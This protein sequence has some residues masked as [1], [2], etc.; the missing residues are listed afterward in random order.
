MS[1][2]QI[3]NQVVWIDIPCRDLDRAIGFY[4]TVLGCAV[5]K[6][7]GKKP[8]GT[9]FELGVLAHSGSEV[10]GCLIVN[11]KS[12]P[13]AHG[14]LVY[15]NCQGRLKEAVAA[16]EPHGGKILEPIHGIGPYGSRA[17]ILDSEGNR[18]ALHST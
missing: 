10:G 4:S 15:L 5:E 8:D 18:V 3:H 12:P 17:V 11:E 14:V 2:E 16:V 7:S 13:S 9:P 6:Q 1:S